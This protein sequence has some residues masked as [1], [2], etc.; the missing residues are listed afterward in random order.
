MAVEREK[1]GLKKWLIVIVLMLLPLGIT[2][3]AWDVMS[4]KVYE[5]Q[6]VKFQNLVNEHQ[7]ALF[8][9]M[10]SYEHALKGGAGFFQ[11][12]NNVT[13]QEWKAYVSAIDVLENFPGINGIGW[14]VEVS[15]E[16][17]PAFIERAKKEISEDFHIHP[18][19]NYPGNFPI[20]YIEPHYL[21]VEAVGLNIGFETNRFEAATQSRDTGN[22]MITKRIILVQD[23]EKTPGF[24]LLHPFYNRGAAT[25]TLEDKRANFRGW[26]YA[27]FIAKNFFKGL[28]SAQG[29]F[30]G[31]QVYDGSEIRDASSIYKEKGSELESHV[32]QF[33]VQRTFEIMGQTWTLVWSSTEKFEQI[34]ASN[35]P[36]FILIA[37]L[38]FSGLFVVF[39]VLVLI[40]TASASQIRGWEYVLPLVAF[41]LISSSSFYLHKRLLREE[42][43]FYRHLTEKEVFSISKSLRSQVMNQ[44]LALNR[45]ASRWETRGRTPVHEW[46]VDAGHYVKDSV[47]LRAV[48]WVDNTYHV[49]WVEPLRGNEKAVGLNIVFNE[50][51]KKALEGAA[52]RRSITLTPPIDLIQGY[53]AIIS[54]SPVFVEDVFDGFIVGIF[55]VQKLINNAVSEFHKNHFSLE[56]AQEGEVFYET[57]STGSKTFVDEKVEK[58]IKIY[59]QTWSLIVKPT[60]R[61]IQENRT[62]LP[63]TVLI[64]GNVLALLLSLTLGFAYRVRLKAA[65]VKDNEARIRAVVENAVDGIIVTDHKGLVE[66]FNPACVDIFGYQAEE[67]IGQPVQTLF[68]EPFFDRVGSSRSLEGIRKDKTQFPLEMAVSE[69][70]LHR[71]HLFTAMVRDITERKEVERMKDEFISTV[72]HELRTPLTSISGGVSLINHKIRELMPED[73]KKII[74]MVLSNCERL[75]YLIN[76]ILDMEKIMA[77][78]LTYDIKTYDILKIT[79]EALAQNQSYAEKYGVGYELVQTVENINVKLDKQRFS[80]ALANLLSNAAKFSPRGETVAVSL[81]QVDPE[82]LKLS[83]KDKGPGIPASFRKK[84]F[85]KFAQADGSTTRNPGGTGLGLNITKSLIEAFGGSVG[86]DSVEGEGSCFYFYLPIA[87]GSGDETL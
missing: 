2:Y 62:Y 87:K 49:R 61:F 6:Y 13:L 71:S 73:A 81:E 18:L 24:L 76:D 19:G 15:K 30:F 37:G 60:D 42:E 10:N 66:S 17:L 57:K 54:Y 46:Q 77:G 79:E 4:K 40:R 58:K 74:D 29:N 12:S 59:D 82:M 20:V 78:K 53:R 5:T 44:L 48:E 25:Y 75:I 47:G 80:Q 72:N 9:R 68:S 3:Y 16:D 45:M 35:E 36:L 56:L 1:I 32:P 34:E 50:D 11:G 64:S 70:R 65:Q 67:M 21:N 28:S 69:V 8:T 7:D 38:F 43:K 85:E 31:L 83:V 41:G 51:R 52:S 14:I 63:E 86:Y 27:P 84:I 39:I 33:K 23:K 26:I 55:D 22:S